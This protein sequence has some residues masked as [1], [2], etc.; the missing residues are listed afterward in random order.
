MATKT[1]ALAVL[2]SMIS[3]PSKLALCFKRCPTL[4]AGLRKNEQPLTFT[5]HGRFQNGALA[6]S[7]RQQPRIV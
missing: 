1:F 6:V 2:V 3:I 5:L 4:Q 7:G